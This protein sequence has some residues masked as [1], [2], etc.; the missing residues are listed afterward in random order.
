[1]VEEARLESVYTSKAYH[2]FESRSLRTASLSFPSQGAQTF[3]CRRTLPQMLFK[4][5]FIY[6]CD[7][8][9]IG[10]QTDGSGAASTWPV[11]MYRGMRL[12][13]HPVKL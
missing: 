4:A 7:L 8:L 10:N 6:S 9:L 5:I 13:L 11:T 3:F 2:G 12:V 1:M